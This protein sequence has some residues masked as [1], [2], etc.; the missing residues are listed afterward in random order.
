MSRAPLKTRI[1]AILDRLVEYDV[2]SNREAPDRRAE[3]G[4]GTSHLWLG[5]QQVEA[6]GEVVDEAVACLDVVLGD[7][8]GDL[9]KV[10]VGFRAPRDAAHLRLLDPVRLRTRRF[11]SAASKS[12]EGPLSIPFWTS[13]RSS[14][15]RISLMR[16]RSS[17]SRSA[18]RTTSLADRYRP[19]FTLSLTSCSSSLVRDTF[20]EAS[21]QV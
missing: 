17:R 12:A 21:L 1:D 20:T 7:V 13:R 16:S 15:S 4:A 10:G 3:L 11:R 9:E 19:L 2:L 6:G 18:S 5:R 8:D 14:S